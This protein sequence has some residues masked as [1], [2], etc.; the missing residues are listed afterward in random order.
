MQGESG[1]ELEPTGCAAPTEKP[2]LG[3]GNKSTT[4]DRAMLIVIAGHVDIGSRA[5]ARA[6]KRH[7]AA[8]HSFGRHACDMA[9]KTDPWNE[10]DKKST[11]KNHS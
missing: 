5:S 10:R 2:F 6:A 4:L 11:H 8:G 1:G 9:H 3:I 7:Q